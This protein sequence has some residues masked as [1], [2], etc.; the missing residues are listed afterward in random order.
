M[1]QNSRH[2][3]L[4]SLFL[5]CH[6][7]GNETQGI[8][9]AHV[10]E[11]THFTLMTDTVA[12]IGYLNQLGAECTHNELSRVF[13]TIC[14]SLD[15]AGNGRAI[16]RIESLIL[17][18]KRKRGAKTVRN[19][20]NLTRSAKTIENF[21]NRALLSTYQFVKDVKGSGITTLNSENQS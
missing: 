20:R 8:F 6:E 17:L 18:R 3:Y 15:D 9:L 7:V 12:L 2:S 10:V 4:S 21:N 19:R 16:R 1:R 13:R 11:A 5:F 14:L